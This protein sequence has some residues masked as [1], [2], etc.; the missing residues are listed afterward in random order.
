[1]LSNTERSFSILLT[2]GG[3]KW[4]VRAR[5]VAAILTLVLSSLSPSAAAVY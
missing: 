5:W 4:Q 1:M 3:S 2:I